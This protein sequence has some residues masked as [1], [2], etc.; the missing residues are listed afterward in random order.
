MNIHPSAIVDPAAQI[1]DSVEVGANSIIEGN[2]VIGEGCVISSGVRIYAGTQ[3]GRN[4]RI[5]HG[6]ALGCEPQD[7]GFDRNCNSGLIIGDNNHFRENMNI[8][9]GSAEGKMTRIGNHNYFMSLTHVAHDC[10]FGDHNIMTQSA[11][12]AGL[13]HVGNRSFISGLVAIHQFVHIGDFAMVAGLAKIVKDVPPYATVDGNP[14]TVIGTNVIAMRRAGMDQE[15]RNIVKR[16]YK[17]IY[18]SGLSL[19]QAL[20]RLES[21]PQT[22]ELENIIRFFKQSRRGV[23]SH[24]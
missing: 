7:L 17:T 13:C 21:E 24:R 10:V 19:A 18:H 12:I 22:I 1:H 11:I 9:R 4:N 14:A 15:T 8:S 3:I 6:V 20:E 23:T 16:A 5:D 2:T